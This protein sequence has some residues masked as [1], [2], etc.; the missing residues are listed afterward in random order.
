MKEKRTKKSGA[1]FFCGGFEV[2]LLLSSRACGASSSFRLLFLF[3]LR[4]RSFVRLLYH[5]CLLW[6]F[7]SF[8]P[9]INTEGHMIEASS[10][11]AGE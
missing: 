9:L 2:V 5:T 10:Q 6:Y 4:V 7:W 8:C 11:S 3:F 1:V